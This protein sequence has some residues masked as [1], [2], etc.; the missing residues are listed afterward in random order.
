M[1]KVMIGTPSYDGRTSVYYT[2]AMCHFA[3][4]AEGRG[5]QAFVRFRA[6]DSIIQR[7]R[8]DL[9]WDAIT[10]DMDDLVM[11]DDDQS[12]DAGA[13][14]RLLGHPVDYVGYPVRNKSDETR[15]NVKYLGELPIPRD[16]KTG[17]LLVD[18]VG[19]GFVRFSRAAMRA[20][21]ERGEPYTDD[22]GNHRRWVF[23]IG[24]SEGRIRGEDM[25]IAE[26]LK[27]AGIQCYLDDGVTISHVGAKCWSGDF[28]VSLAE[29]ER[30]ARETLP[31]PDHA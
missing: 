3:A 26:S 13:V 11:I 5:I 24:P 17:M 23:D 8:N 29:T 2:S 18:G 27:A 22:D 9:L 19:T 10:Q 21:W 1:R 20:A 28:K 6:Y 25:A 30:Q 14:L 7:A 15:F 16:I 4:V 12:F 31:I